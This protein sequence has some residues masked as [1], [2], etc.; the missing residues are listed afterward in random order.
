[1]AHAEPGRHR[2][3]HL[4]FCPWQH[5]SRAWR[6]G[7][8]ALEAGLAR[9]IHYIGYR[10]NGFPDEERIDE[11][12]TI[13]RIGA[14]P[15]RPGS[16]RLL[17]ALSLPKWWRAAARTQSSKEVALVQAHSLAALPAGIMVARRSGAGLLYDAHELETEREGWNPAIRWIAKRVERF[18]IKRCDHTIVVNDS[19]REWYEKAYPGVSV[20]TVRNVPVIPAKTGPSQ[21]R[22]RL[23]LSTK[24]LLYVY[25][26]LLGHGRG[27]FEMIE[28]FGGLGDGHHLAFVG[29]GPL[30]AQV[31]AAIELHANIHFHPA[32]NQSELIALLSGADVGAFLPSGQ[33]MSY[34]NSLP[35]KIF[36]YCASGLGLLVSDAPEL[37]RFA[38]EYPVARSIQLT[39]E[40]IRRTVEQWSAEEIRTGRANM[41]F[42]PPNWA[43][44]VKRLLEAYAI[45]ERRARERLAR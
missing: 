5:E 38:G 39:S 20:S 13:K 1:M 25:C 7:A 24:P 41:R 11:R 37:A 40:N 32:V 15:A 17:R 28:A 9:E 33:S 22:E 36:E 35:N 12:Q 31:R 45:V 21:L 29:F 27:I 8:S 16:A 6:A 43:S 19:I 2:H 30:E 4:Y 23:G 34:H 42:E 26:G 44:E 3:V 10:A 18:L 14:H